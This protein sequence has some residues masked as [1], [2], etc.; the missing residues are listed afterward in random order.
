MLR[1]FFDSKASVHDGGHRNAE[2]LKRDFFTSSVGRWKKDLNA[3]QIVEIEEAC[4]ELMDRFDYRRAPIE[5]RVPLAPRLHGKQTAALARKKRYFRDEYGPLVL[6][7]AEARVNLT[8][9]EAARGAESV[10]R[11]ILILRHDVDHDYE[12][13]LR[14]ARWEHEHGLRATYCI[15]HTAWYYGKLVKD[16]MERILQE[17]IERTA[18]AGVRH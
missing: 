13:A 14:M 8:W 12:T 9:A 1:R 2:N 18:S 6:P 3:A 7:H 10:E 15:L 17:Y 4:G 5:P 16:R 11:E